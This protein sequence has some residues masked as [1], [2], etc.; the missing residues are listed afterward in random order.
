MAYSVL[1][2]KSASLSDGGHT[3]QALQFT[4]NVSTNNKMI[5][6]AQAGGS[7]NSTTSVKDNLGNSAFKIGA[8]NSPAS[9]GEG[10][11]WALTVVS[12]LNNT[13]P[14]L[15]MTMANSNTESAMSIEEVS[16][17][18]TANDATQLDGNVGTATGTGSGTLSVTGDTTTATAEML[19]V[20]YGDNGN[21]STIT[22]GSGFTKDTGDDPSGVATAMLE[23]KNSTGGA[24][25]GTVSSSASAAWELIM[26]CFKLAA[27]GTPTT[28]VVTYGHGPN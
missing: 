23:H 13:M 8:V 5:I 25:T 11:L 12:G 22:A 7:G 24:E 14:T 1:Q 17:L 16:G 9:D 19:C 4:N 21:N 27:A 18:N 28:P 20:S 3:T 2:A 15:T 6:R 26:C 10:S